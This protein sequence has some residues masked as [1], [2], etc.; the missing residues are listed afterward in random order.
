MKMWTA[1]E[2][3]F[4][5]TNLHLVW[6]DLFRLELTYTRVQRTLQSRELSYSRVWFWVKLVFLPNT[7]NIYMKFGYLVIM[8]VL[9]TWY[10]HRMHFKG[11]NSCISII[12]KYL[13]H[14][15]CWYFAVSFLLWR[16]Y[17]LDFCCYTLSI[18]LFQS[19]GVIVFK[20]ITNISW[21]S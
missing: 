7:L 4:K 19:Y 21:I 16:V 5:L 12:I 6:T 20:Y 3:H 2:M 10:I 14:F 1:C 8:Q 15:S 18:K 13:V 11:P 17:T 9:W